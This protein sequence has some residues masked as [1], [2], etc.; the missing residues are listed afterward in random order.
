[1]NGPPT[2]NST[3]RTLS[4][5]ELFPV[6]SE[7]ELKEAEVNLAGYLEIALLVHEEQASFARRLDPARASTT[8]KERSNISL[9]N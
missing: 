2:D 9:K 3:Q 6:L 7:R 4:L 5:R 1:M 8:M